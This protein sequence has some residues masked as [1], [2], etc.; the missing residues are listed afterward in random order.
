MA[1][2]LAA[3]AATLAELDATLAALLVAQDAREQAGAVPL[4]PLLGPED[5]QV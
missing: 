4:R 1:G 2:T 5:R 3:L